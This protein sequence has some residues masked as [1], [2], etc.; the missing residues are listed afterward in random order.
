MAASDRVAPILNG[1]IMAALP[2]SGNVVK[3]E[4]QA[5][6]GR[7]NLPSVISD[8]M[9]LSEPRKAGNNYFIDITIDL[10]DA[11]MAAAFELGSGI[12]GQKG[13][14]YKIAPKEKQALAFPWE[15]EQIPWGSPK[16]I[17]MGGGG[18]LFL[19]RF[20][21]HPGVAARPYFVPAVDAKEREVQEILGQAMLNTA[22][23]AFDLILT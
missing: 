5:N 22:S 21:E 17:G 14:K 10:D 6:V 15:P 7:N 2:K 19:F 18:A 20:V 23:I 8:A 1:A 4:A 13:E 12:H 9:K 16:F 3:S 11:P